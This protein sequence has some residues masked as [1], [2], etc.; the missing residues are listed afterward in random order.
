MQWY[1][2]YTIKLFFIAVKKYIRVNWVYRK[3]KL[4]DKKLLGVMRY[5]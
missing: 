2:R 5:E 3:S 4:Q 1:Y